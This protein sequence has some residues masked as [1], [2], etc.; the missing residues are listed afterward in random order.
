MKNTILIIDDSLVNRKLLVSALYEEYK[1]VEETNGTDGLNKAISILPDLILLDVS[2][3]EVDGFMTCE[4]LKLNEKT[5]SIPIIFITAQ[6]DEESELKAFNLGASDYITK[7]INI[8]IM[9]ARIKT[10]LLIQSLQE[11][12]SI[13]IQELEKTIKVLESKMTRVK[14]SALK[15]NIQ[16][17]SIADQKLENYVFNE[18][19]FELEDI[20][21]SMDAIV[22]LFFLKNTLELELQFKLSQDLGKYAKTLRFYPLFNS[23][24][25]AL[26]NLSK[27]LE[28]TDLEPTKENLNMSLECLESLVFTLNYW[29]AQVLNKEISN[30][31]AYDNSMFSDIE[32]IMLTLT[33]SLDTIEGDIEFF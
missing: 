13:K 2:M 29:R 6:D 16:K 12:K 32:T 8:P 26:G 11:E 21:S 1:T 17:D 28:R 7:P 18:H 10:H 15:V 14:P 30:P 23:L 9:E 19:W 4:R 20:E 25:Q 24:G 33:N 31:N 27:L 22:N 3:P 5:A